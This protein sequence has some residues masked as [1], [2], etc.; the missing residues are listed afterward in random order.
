MFYEKYVTFIVMVSA[1]MNT[2]SVVFFKK[3]MTLLVMFYSLC[4]TRFVL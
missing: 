1:N 4:F 3:Y 2:I